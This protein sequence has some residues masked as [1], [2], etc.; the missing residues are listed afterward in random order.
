[1]VS[2][3]KSTKD[4]Q[5]LT[6]KSDVYKTPCSC[7][8]MYIGQMGCHN[9]TR[10]SEHIRHQT[11]EPVTSASQTFCS[12]H[13]INIDKIEVISNICTYHPHIISEAIEIINTPTTPT[14]KMVT[15]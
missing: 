10:I 11:G 1:M 9:S 3:F 7:G 12:N 5:H 2:R 6:K 4:R 15:D 8:K 14:V 13:H